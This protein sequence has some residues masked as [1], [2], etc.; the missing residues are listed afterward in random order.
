MP[1]AVFPIPTSSRPAVERRVKRRIRRSG[2]VPG[3]RGVPIGGRCGHSKRSPSGRPRGGGSDSHNMTLNCVWRRHW[4][5]F[6]IGVG[7][8]RKHYWACEDLQLLDS[9]RI[10]NCVLVRGMIREQVRACRDEIALRIGIRKDESHDPV[11]L[12][13]VQV[14]VGRLIDCVVHP[15]RLADHVG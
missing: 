11:R 13:V 15:H 8:K 14:D 2:P 10:G 9:G 6:A 7:G 5:G 3:G 12:D 1:L 4:I